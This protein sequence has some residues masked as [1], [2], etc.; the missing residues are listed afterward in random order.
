MKNCTTNSSKLITMRTLFIA[1]MLLSC[2]M[3]FGQ[4]TAQ[5][6]MVSEETPNTSNLD[7]F[8]A[9]YDNTSGIVKINWVIT[10]QDTQGKLVIEKSTDG[11]NYSYMG[12]VPAV[13]STN[14][15]TYTCRDNNPAEGSNFYRLK[16]V[17]ASNAEF[18]YESTAH[19]NTS[20]PTEMPKQTLP[21]ASE[22]QNDE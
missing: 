3:M 22:G 13:A 12:K 17:T 5:N 8:T 15:I 2:N 1:I 9:T 6:T 7:K 19:V 21:L 4:L 14:K 20:Q 16:A 11:V 10:G 18:I